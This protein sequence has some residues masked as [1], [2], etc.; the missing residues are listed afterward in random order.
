M[1]VGPGLGDYLSKIKEAG[2]KVDIVHEDT[3]ISKRQYE[4]IP[5]ESLKVIAHK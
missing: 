1:V 5:L 3:E 4:G 2:F